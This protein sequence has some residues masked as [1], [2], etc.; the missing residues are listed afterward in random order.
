VEFDPRVIDTVNRGGTRPIPLC[1]IA[2]LRADRL[3]LLCDVL[4]RHEVSSLW[5]RDPLRS[6]LHAD[7]RDREGGD[8]PDQIIQVGEQHFRL[9]AEEQHSENKNRGP[10]QAPH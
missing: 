3:A 1:K 8:S 4:Q 10:D 7:I 6:R 2:A 9:L 5:H